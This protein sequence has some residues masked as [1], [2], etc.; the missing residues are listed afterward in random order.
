MYLAATQRSGR[1]T[2]IDI[3]GHVRKTLPYP[4]RPKA[5]L[6]ILGTVGC[7]KRTLS[8][9][10]RKL[11][12]FDCLVNVFV[13]FGDTTLWDTLQIWVASACKTGEPQTT[14][15]QSRKPRTFTRS[16]IQSLVPRLIE[17]HILR[18]TSRNL[19]AMTS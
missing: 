2:L 18:K 12:Q 3:D 9:Q 1:R 13:V 15:T 4:K 14:R 8:K 5:N 17:Q 6:L 7:L 16:H 10:C 19:R 11:V